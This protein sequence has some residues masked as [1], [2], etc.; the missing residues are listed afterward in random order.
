MQSD[1]IPV[2]LDT[3]P[4]SDID[5]ALALAYLLAQPRCELVGVST[6]TGNTRE[7][8]AIVRHLCNVSGRGEVPVFAGL[9]EPM[10]SGPGQPNVPHFRALPEA[11]IDLQPDTGDAIESLYRHIAGRPGEITLLA[12]GPMT[13]VGELFL[14]HPD[15]PRLFKQIMLMCGAFRSRGDREVPEVEHNVRCDPE[16]ARVLFE[17]AVHGT[18]RA[19]GLDVTMD[20]RMAED[21][22]RASFSVGGPVLLAIL[23]MAELWFKSAPQIT[24][25][26]P[27]AAALLFAPEVGHFARGDVVVVAGQTDWPGKTRWQRNPEGAVYVADDVDPAAFFKHYFET[28][29]G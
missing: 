1:R 14:R 15:A 13:N 18:V 23:E 11:A 21:E 6:V 3:D 7:R 8:A 20:C 29:G 5:D 17:R 26:D 9:K 16:A 24:F 25:H 28:V 4:G 12:I 2:W 19:V 27:L 10:G 22:C